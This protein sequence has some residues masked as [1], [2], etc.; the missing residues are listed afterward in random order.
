MRI[1][2]V[3]WLTALLAVALLA[4]PVS[5]SPTGASG[6]T[7]TSTVTPAT[8]IRQVALGVSMLPYDSSTNFDTF[9]STMGRAPA[10]WSIWSDWGGNSAFPT[11]LVDRLRDAGTVPF[12][13]WQP[14]GSA[15]PPGHPES[16]PLQES[17]GTDYGKIIGGDWDNYIHQYAQAAVGHGPILVRFTHEMDGIWFPFG[18]GRC[19]NTPAKFVA[20]WKHVVS[21]FRA[22]GATN[23]KFVWSPRR[24]S[25][26]EEPMYPG[27]SWV[28][29]VGVT[30]YN[31]AYVKNKPW[32]NLLTL[33][34]RATSGLSLYA[35]SKPWIVAETGSPDHPGSRP[36][37]ISLGYKQLYN[38]IPNIALIV[39]FD[40]DMTYRAKNQP[41]WQ[42]NTSADN[43]AYK[44]LLVATRFQGTIH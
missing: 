32:T 7:S 9:T 19:T 24:A 11:A 33:V 44:A 14:V 30:A 28:D 27:D 21:I 1:R 29:Y 4:S 43:S 13:W 20:M 16:P 42:L 22:D 37:W 31:W 36:N 8:T 34:Q 41:N 12:I 38:K 18:V 25:L 15:T 3:Q 39:Y 6:A 23:V 26:V 17:C 40:I 10:T 2:I 35:G 5:A